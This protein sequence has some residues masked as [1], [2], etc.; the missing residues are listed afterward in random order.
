MKNTRFPFF[1]L[2]TA[3]FFLSC[4]TTRDIAKKGFF[5]FEYEN[6]AYQ[7]ISIAAPSGEGLNF[8]VKPEGDHH[9]FKAIDQDQDG[10]MDIIQYGAISLEKASAIYSFGIQKAVDQG[11]LQG[12]EQARI[13][14][15]TEEPF[16]YTIQTIGLY[17]DVFYNRFTILNTQNN[18]EE[19]FLDMDANGLLDQAK[20]TLR[21]S[22][23]AQSLYQHTLDEGIRQNKIYIRF[24]KIIVKSLPKSPPF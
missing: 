15:Y 22:T 1:T 21:D 10:I 11:K 12:K 16:R 5:P 13:F 24:D 4:S 9:A 3:L 19:L 17:S 8:L 6:E 14:N 18:T 23:E 2:L 7:I 20:K